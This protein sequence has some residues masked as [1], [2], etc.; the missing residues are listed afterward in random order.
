MKYSAIALLL[1]SA[2]F[3]ASAGTPESIQFKGLV[4]KNNGV[5]TRFDVQVPSGQQV[6]LTLGNG[7][8]L[9]LATPGS[10]ESAAAPMARL[11]SA[12]GKILHTATYRDTGLASISLDYLVC[13]GRA[14]Y[15]SPAPVATPFCSHK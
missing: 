6:V 14:K 13:E 10:R 15:M 5:P 4:R 12:S 1:L 9:E 7:T 3:V 2:A 11:V 8:K